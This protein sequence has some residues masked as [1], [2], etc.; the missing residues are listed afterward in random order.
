MSLPTEFISAVNQLIPQQ[1][2]FD[3]PLSALAFGTDASFYR[4][5]PKLVVRVSAE[6]EVVALL[7]LAGQYQKCRLPFAPRV[8]AYR[9]RPLVIRC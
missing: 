5:I 7:Q 9:A 6:H 2:R 3:D 4:L 8:P 1:R